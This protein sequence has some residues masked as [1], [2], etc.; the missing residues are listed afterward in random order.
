[1]L[2]LNNSILGSYSREAVG[3][4]PAK[5]LRQMNLQI[6][7]QI[8]QSPQQHQVYAQLQNQK[9][10]IKCPYFSLSTCPPKC[11]CTLVLYKMESTESK[12][13]IQHKDKYT[14]KGLYIIHPACLHTEINA[15]QIPTYQMN[16]QMNGCKNIRSQINLNQIFKKTKQKKKTT[17]TT[18]TNSSATA[19]HI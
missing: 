11:L 4:L 18:H 19:G 8:K 2:T 12:D 5:K 7:L 6:H 15:G 14:F 9:C 16:R 17:K 3:H 10:R 13:I 1:M